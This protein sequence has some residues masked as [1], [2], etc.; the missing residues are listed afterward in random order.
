MRGFKR[1]L[2]AAGMWA[3]AGLSAQAAPSE[4]VAPAA[5]LLK[6]R[7]PVAGKYIVVFK[8][9]SVEAAALTG[10]QS[11]REAITRL[12]GELDARHGGKTLR[13]FHA[14]LQGFAV[15]LSEAQALRLS[16]DPRV[17]YVEE[18]A[19][20]L[21]QATRS[22]QLPSGTP[23]LYYNL[24]NLD[25]IDQRDLPL[26]YV[27]WYGARGAGVHAYILDSGVTP[28][29]DF[30]GRLG[31]GYNAVADGAGTSDC[32]TGGHANHGTAVAGILGGNT[33]GVAPAVT[34]HPVRVMT[35]G[36]GMV[37]DALAGLDW[38]TEN[39]LLPAVANI[40]FAATSSRSLDEAV[41]GLMDS[42]VVTVV[43]AGNGPGDDA[44]TV[45][46]A[47]LPAVLTVGG[48]FSTD[49]ASSLSNQGSCL[50]LFAPGL[51]ET[52]LATP[53]NGKG[54]M[55]GTSVS[56]PHVSGAAAL[57]LQTHRAAT[58]QEV[59]DFLVNT[60]TTGRLSGL[61][62]GSPNRLLYTGAIDTWLLHVVSAQ[63]PMSNEGRF[64]AADWNGDKRPDLFSITPHGPSGRT[65]VRILSGAANFQSSFGHWATV[66]HATNKDWAFAVADWNKDGKQDVF[67]INRAG[68]TNTEVHILS[69]ATNFQTFLLQ[70]NT[71]LLPSNGNWDYKV[72]DWNRDGTQDLVAINAMGASGRV[73]VNILSGASNFRSMLLHA[74]TGL[75]SSDPAMWEY[76]LAEVNRDAT[77]D[78]VAIRRSGESSSTEVHALS[79]ASAFADF[80]LQAGTALHPT[81]GD[82]TFEVVRW[83]DAN[84]L[85]IELFG[86]GPDLVAINR[87]APQGVEVHIL[88]P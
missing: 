18:V 51:A 44:C 64:E 13:V 76:E 54:Y 67:A 3:L 27:Q 61:T 52:T 49:E 14:A 25:R 69:G 45:T 19:M 23:G 41:Q 88:N 56:A 72:T 79:G 53:A 12:S 4:K 87:N 36:G 2:L 63:P 28:H 1:G 30:A 71:W 46:P 24:W 39:R 85:G 59:H 74:N 17:A 58:Q 78:L 77:V 6:V 65:E 83:D 82:W 47:R 84:L 34:L 11:S 31:D 50:D 32:T 33:Y 55:A 21:P 8:K 81:N 16:E 42:G 7:E 10:K 5:K 20:I 29:A 15:E 80:A 68:A 26:N 9:E 62:L 43:A 66:L 22:T 70:V 60:A 37:F 86:N 75:P 73:E 40:S 38:V 48:S 35:C 57:Y